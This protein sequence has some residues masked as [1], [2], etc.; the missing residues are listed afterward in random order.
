[1]TARRTVIL[2]LIAGVVHNVLRLLATAVGMRPGIFNYLPPYD[3]K[4]PAA[5]NIGSGTLVL[6]VIL[7][8]IAAVGLRAWRRPQ[9]E[10]SKSLWT[11][12]LWAALLTVPFGLFAV[13]LATVADRTYGWTLFVLV[14]VV[15]GFLATLLL[16]QRFPVGA[17]D[18]VMVS[19]LSVMLLGGA[20]FAVAVEGLICLIMALPIALPLAAIGGYLAFQIHRTRAAR[21]PATFLLIVGLTPFGAGLERAFLPA[22]N[23]FVVTTAIDLPAAPERVWQTILQPARLPQPSQALF[24]SGVAYPLAS[25]IEGRGLTAVRYCDFSTGKLVEPVILWDES[26]RLRFRVASNPLPMQEWTPY[27]QIHP[28]HLEGFLVSRQGEFRLIPRAGGG[29]HL[30]ATTWYQHHL[31][32]AHYWRWWSDYIIHQV[33]YMV[34]D[35]IRERVLSPASTEFA[36]T[37]PARPAHPLP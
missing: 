4:L 23:L 18:A 15:A 3:A 9:S 34:L 2:F 16:A 28:P 7:L 24:R 14:P 12:A 25:H 10:P 11:S 20:L 22:D 19:V 27:A 32:P 26:R 33:H 29:T 31:A 35:N 5:H 30:E 37:S 8:V 36:A 21:H 17:A 1:M 13:E 6:L